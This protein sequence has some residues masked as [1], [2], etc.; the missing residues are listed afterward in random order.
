M[1]SRK[2]GGARHMRHA[3]QIAVSPERLP[4]QRMAPHKRRH[5]SMVK[6]LYM[7]S[8]SPGQRRREGTPGQLMS[9]AAHC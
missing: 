3:G 8:R 7:Y 5:R 6:D 4:C 1:R 2:Q 9:K